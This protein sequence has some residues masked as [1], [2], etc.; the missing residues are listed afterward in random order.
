MGR[1]A[2]VVVVGLL[3]AV[4]VGTGLLGVVG[5]LTIGPGPADAVRYFDSEY[6]F[7]NAVWVLVGLL[8]WW[9]LRRPGERALVTRLVLA[10]FVLGGVAR[11]VSVVATGWPATVFSAALAVELLLVPV[12][13]V[14]HRRA[15]P[16]VGQVAD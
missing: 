16:A 8:L 4:P 2:L 10:S 15:F 11:L 14:W 3:G 6:R 12:V 9:S 7:L 1:R 13:L 5:G